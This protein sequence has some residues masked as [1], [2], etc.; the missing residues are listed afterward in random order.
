MNLNFNGTLHDILKCTR[1]NELSFS[2]FL[3]C[4]SVRQYLV[5]VLFK[6]IKELCD[7]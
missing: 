4:V 3:Y 5:Q 1:L 6:D 7:N 2:S